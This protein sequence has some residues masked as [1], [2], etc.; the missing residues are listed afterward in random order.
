[1]GAGNRLRVY[2]CTVFGCAVRAG[3]GGRAGCAVPGVQGYRLGGMEY[4]SCRGSDAG[5][6]SAVG[7]IET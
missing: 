6:E 2:E 1:M 7:I 5:Q 3:C 4:G